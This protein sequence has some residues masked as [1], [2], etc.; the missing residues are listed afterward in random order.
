L[1][2]LL[3]FFLHSFI[4]YHLIIWINIQLNVYFYFF[5]RSLFTAIDLLQMKFDEYLMEQTCRLTKI[6]QILITSFCFCHFN[7]SIVCLLLTIKLRKIVNVF[8]G[9]R[10]NVIVGHL[11]LLGCIAPKTLNYLTSNFEQK[12]IVCTIFDIYVYIIQKSQKMGQ[13][14]IKLV[15]QYSGL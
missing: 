1:I 2:L 8:A 10:V 5:S 11:L 12:R 14:S 3:V 6:Y 9:D 4:F 13:I 7:L 15:H